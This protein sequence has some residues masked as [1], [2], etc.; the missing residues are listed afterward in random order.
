M[1]HATVD[2]FICKPVHH[3]PLAYKTVYQPIYGQRGLEVT[4]DTVSVYLRPIWRHLTVLNLSS[5]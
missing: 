2:H 1:Y 4:A 5:V 3:N